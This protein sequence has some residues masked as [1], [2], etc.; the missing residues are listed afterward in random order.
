[1]GATVAASGAGGGKQRRQVAAADSRHLACC[2]VTLLLPLLCYTLA[3]LRC[4]D[5]ALC[6][7][8]GNAVSLLASRAAVL[9]NGPATGL[10]KHARVPA[11]VDERAAGL[12]LKEPSRPQQRTAPAASG[13]GGD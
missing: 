13:G 12:D 9:S 5:D 6:K 1:M 10:I 8:R 2:V 11:M 3:G 7:S 4:C